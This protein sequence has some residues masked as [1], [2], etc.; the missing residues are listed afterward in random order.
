ME[1]RKLNL[2]KMENL[3]GGDNLDNAMCTL[4]TAAWAVGAL[5]VATGLGLA[6]WA[7]GA[8]GVAYCNSQMVS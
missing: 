3:N 7:V 1:T 5:T 2:E 6:V 8:A 4:S